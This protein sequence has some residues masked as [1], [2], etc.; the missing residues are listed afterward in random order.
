MN[1]MSGQGVKALFG[2][3]DRIAKEK[4][5]SGTSKSKL[6]VRLMVVGIP[7]S[8]KSSLINRLIGKRAAQVGDRPGVTR[9]KQWLSL[10][11]G[12]QLLDTP[13]ILWT[14]FED[15]EVGLNLAFCGSIRDEIM[16]IQDLALELLKVLVQDHAELLV[17][18]YG[19]TAGTVI[20]SELS[21]RGDNSMRESRLPDENDALMVMEE[22]AAKRGY[23]LPGK[24]IDYERTARALL[25]DFRAGKIGRI[26]LEQA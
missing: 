23:I 24:R 17:E 3:L 25:D 18:R 26:T 20:L 7:N 12:M 11:N 22:I 19:I 6:P 10:E 14:K 5:A 4:T 9:G 2:M 8:G 21:Q 13:G 15:P 1:S 16:D